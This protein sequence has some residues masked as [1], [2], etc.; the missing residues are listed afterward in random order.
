MNRRKTPKPTKRAT[1]TVSE[2]TVA[3]TGTVKRHLV[4]LLSIFMLVGLVTG[5]V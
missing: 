2:I 4:L 3:G 1:K 5:A